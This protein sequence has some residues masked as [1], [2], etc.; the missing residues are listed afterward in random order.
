MRASMD[1]GKEEHRIGKLSVHPDVLVKRYKPDLRP[2]EPHDGS[3]DGE[4]NEHAV[5]AQN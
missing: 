1:Y 3:A 5:D 2:N 4:Q